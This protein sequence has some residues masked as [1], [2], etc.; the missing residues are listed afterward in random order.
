MSYHLSSLRQVAAA[1]LLLLAVGGTLSAC[2]DI[3]S[4]NHPSSPKFRAYINP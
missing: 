3:Q 4:D 2:A 1:V